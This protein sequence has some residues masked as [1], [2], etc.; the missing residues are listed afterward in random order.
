M[1]DLFEAQEA[2][3]PKAKQ[4]GHIH[5]TKAKLQ[6]IS[7]EM[8]LEMFAEDKIKDDS[9]KQLKL[10]SSK[11]SKKDAKLRQSKLKF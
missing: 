1:I 2:S 5:E 11:E 4:V 9:I 8:E 6:K 7:T 10:I 3:T